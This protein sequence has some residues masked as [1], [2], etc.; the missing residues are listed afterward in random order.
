MRKYQDYEACS[1]A[2][3]IIDRRSTHT[4]ARGPRLQ[5]G[6]DPTF[7]WTTG[8]RSKQCLNVT[9]VTMLSAVDLPGSSLP[10]GGEK[11]EEAVGP[12]RIMPRPRYTTST[13]D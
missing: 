5:T 1:L 12:T 10:A 11:P 8:N 9:L 6:Q 4:I 3:R 13:V 2:V 7:A